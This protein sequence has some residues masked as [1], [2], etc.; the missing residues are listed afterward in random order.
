MQV[1]NAQDEKVIEELKLKK[2][3]GTIYTFEYFSPVEQNLIIEPSIDGDANLLFYPKRKQITVG[4]ECVSNIQFETKTGH[5]ITGKIE[6]PTEGVLIR[7]INTKTKNEVVSTHTD[8]TGSY[9]VGPLYD[10]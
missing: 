8:S 6:P 3:T 10:D 1:L 4:G 5:V 7:I 2:S 9:K